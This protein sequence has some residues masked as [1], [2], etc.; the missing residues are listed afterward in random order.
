VRAAAA[1]VLFLAGGLAG[2]VIRG[3]APTAGAPDEPNFLLLVRGTE[4]D[5][6]VPVE[7]LVQ[8]YSAWAGEL[9]AAGRLVA[10]EKLVDDSGRW[11]SG[12]AVETRSQS[13]VSGYFVISA[14]DYGQAMDIARNSPHVRYGGTFE[15][16]RIDPLE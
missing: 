14:S 10:A 5:A 1:V 13:D 4:P 16:R 15:I 9:A 11:I 12:S 8:E 7:T 3:G 2:F 6:T